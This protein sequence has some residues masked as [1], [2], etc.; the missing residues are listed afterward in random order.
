[1]GIGDRLRELRELRGLTQPVVSARTG[2]G[3]SSLSEFE[4]EKRE[5]SVAQLQALAKCYRVSLTEILEEHH[6][7]SGNMVLWREKPEHQAAELEA[8][9]LQLCR[10]YQN[11]ETW[12]GVEAPVRLPFADATDSATFTFDD[13]E[14]LARDTRMLLCLGDRP[15]RT[16]L[17]AL[18]EQCGLKIFHLPFEPTGT[19]ASTKS[20][21]FGVG[22]LLNAR[23]ARWRRNFDLAHELFHVLTWERFDHSE[24]ASSKQEEK[25]ANAFASHLLLP[26]DAVRMAIHQRLRN[27]GLPLEGLFEIAR[28]FDV[29]VDAL[30]WR[31]KVIYG[32]TQEET[33]KAIERAKR[34]ARAF[35]ERP[36]ETPPTRPTR[37]NALAVTA[38]RKG[39]V[40][41]GRCAE[42]L[43]ISRA[44]AQEYVEQEDSSDEAFELPAA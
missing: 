24:G 5:P 30:L 26:H 2:I 40:S 29:S 23:N 25:L 11:L 19:A 32:R 8:Q 22:I 43:G 42:Y 6:T 9:F 18:E 27:R 35:E 17:P 13:A 36:G 15:A 7:R 44:E 4:H 21:E 34:H 38:L 33:L 41:V 31:A 3:V 28:D 39:E 10:Q 16:L 20:D 14:A 12:C 1:M 37:F